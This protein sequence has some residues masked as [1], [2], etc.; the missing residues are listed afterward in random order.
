LN[1]FIENFFYHYSYPL[2]YVICLGYFLFLYF[3]IGSLFLA[4][5]KFLAN[6][7][8]IHKIEAKTLK[9]N[10]T[11]FEIKHSV[12]SI[13]I[14]GFSIL[15]I[16]Y[17]VR[18]NSIKFLPDTFLNILGGIVIL[19]LWNEIHFYISHRILHQKYLLKNVH[20]I[21]HKSY[22]PTIYSVY[23]FHWIEA[24]ILST[25]PLTI[26][27]FIPISMIAVFIYPLV[28]ILLNF[29]GHSN[30]RFGNGKG[31]D[32]KNFGTLHH[33]HHSKGKRNFGFAIN[34]LD[35]LFSNNKK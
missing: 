9:K 22:I 34:I 24:L 15:P 32:W 6:K 31:N 27:P 8:I 19:T 13:V 5:C 30:Y 3:G 33:Q 2:L 20:Y 12:K 23:S 18:N 10:Q 16:V 7:T 28:S 26:I 25:V 1:Y 4:S 17:L 35:R 29:A 11:S 14:F 21:H